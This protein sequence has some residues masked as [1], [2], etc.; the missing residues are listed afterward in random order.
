MIPQILLLQYF[1]AAVQK[2]KKKNCSLQ[3]EKERGKVKGPLSTIYGNSH[4]QLLDA[5]YLM[6]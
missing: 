4:L 5:V 3:E 2:G 6:N 1:I